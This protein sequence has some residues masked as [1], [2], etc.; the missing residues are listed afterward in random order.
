MCGGGGS[1]SSAVL[2]LVGLQSMDVR[3][4]IGQQQQQLTTELTTRQQMK[5]RGLIRAHSLPGI[6][7]EVAQAEEVSDVVGEEGG[8]RQGRSV[9]WQSIRAECAWYRESQEGVFYHIEKE[10]EEKKT[11]GSA[12]V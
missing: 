10:E 1:R 12:G 11:I 3:P 7:E 6:S 4:T 2:H 5:E 8:S 9:R